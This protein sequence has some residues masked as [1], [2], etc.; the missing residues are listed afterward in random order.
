MRESVASA[1]GA[2][3]PALSA[4]PPST[5]PQKPAHP[6]A[7]HCDLLLA[8][9]LVHRLWGTTGHGMSRRRLGPSRRSD[10]NRICSNTHQENFPE[11]S[12]SYLSLDQPFVVE[13][14]V[15][16][17]RQVRHHTA[18][19]GGNLTHLQRL[20]IHPAHAAGCFTDIC[21]LL[22]QSQESLGRLRER[23]WAQ[24]TT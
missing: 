20:P 11:S 9:L 8:I 17:D 10:H 13:C 15:D 24:R 21:S 1:R 6:H 18:S 3:P 4:G 7:L 2:S 12:L 19:R 5:R 16:L 14:L 23:A 22:G